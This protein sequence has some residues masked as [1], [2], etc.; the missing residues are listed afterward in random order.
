MKITSSSNT[1]ITD[2]APKVIETGNGFLLNTQYY[3]KEK[4]VPVPFE[5][6]DLYGSPYSLCTRKLLYLQAFS[7]LFPQD[8][9]GIVRD[10][11]YPNR[12]YM[13]TLSGF[14]SGSTE[15]RLITFEETENGEITIL[16][17]YTMSGYQVLNFIDQDSNY[18]YWTL[19]NE[20]NVYLYRM[21]KTT[22]SVTSTYTHAPTY[23]YGYLT[24]IHSDDTYIYLMYYTAQS[25]YTI[26]ISKISFTTAT[27]TGIYRGEETAQTNYQFTNIADDAYQVDENTYGI[28]SYNMADTAQPLDLYQYDTSKTLVNGYTMQSVTITW[29]D[30]KSEIAF[31]NTGALTNTQRNFIAEFN[32]VKYLNVVMYQANY[33]TA[34]YIPYQGIYT[35]R[36]DSPTALTFTGYNQIDGA[37]QIGGFIYDESREHLIVAKQN[38]FQILKFNQ[39]T[40]KY[41]S[42]NFEIPACYCVGLDELQSL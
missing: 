1:T 10:T 36:I 31:L 17:N 5:T 18:I 35:F 24:K 7:W 25:V 38:A 6:C 22:F 23:A 11:T 26:T 28:Y 20:K 4:L 21:H 29:N 34:N 42:T 13:R 9:F 32:G 8:E 39:T 16:N 3:T 2:I 19:R 41:E 15:T 27:S 37:K 40:L 30:K 12:Y 33:T 14:V